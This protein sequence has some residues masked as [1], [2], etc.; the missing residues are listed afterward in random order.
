[1][2][3]TIEFEEL[4]KTYFGG[5]V[6]AVRGLTLEVSKGEVLGLVGLNGAGKTSMIRVGGGLILPTSGTVR[7]NGFDIVEEKVKASA[8]VGWV[9][10]FPNFDPR[11]RAWEL[12]E[13]LGGYNGLS[14][15]S[16]RASCYSLLGKVGLAGCEM[17]RLG[18]FSQ[19]MKKR[20][21]LATAI[22]ARPDN[23]L[24]DELLNGLDPEGIRYVRE[25]I[26][27]LRKD[28]A[29]VLL[30]SHILSEV[31]NMAD[32]IAILHNGRLL[33]VVSREEL[34]GST[35]RRLRVRVVEKEAD[36]SAYLSSVGEVV[37]EGIYLT[38]ANP[39]SEAWQIN[40]ELVRRGCKVAEIRI[41]REDLESLFFRLIHEAR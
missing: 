1:V 7:L 26:F 24:L 28:G 6:P 32:R 21:S 39:T 37:R 9:P 31:E 30:S 2:F 12:L 16:F 35:A 36:A 15:P 3:G 29:S 25:L 19:G 40:D 23:L 11:A 13:Y 22:L 34:E 20:F 27:S 17:Q 5:K 14:G 41:E 10:E 4:T 18:S 8:S 33:K 38:V